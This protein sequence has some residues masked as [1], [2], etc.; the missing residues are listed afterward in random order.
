MQTSYSPSLAGR[1]TGLGQVG[2]PC[3][4]KHGGAVS[5]G[6]N[7]NRSFCS[8]LGK[9]GRPEQCPAGSLAVLCSLLQA[10]WWAAGGRKHD[11][12]RAVG[13]PVGQTPGGWHGGASLTPLCHPLLWPSAHTAA[14]P[15][16]VEHLT[17]V[18]GS[19][20]SCPDAEEYR[21]DACHKLVWFTDS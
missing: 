19:D 13:L 1:S 15:V 9:Q 18:F 8:A 4:S 5:V 17:V 10:G 6:V 16:A 20:G 11:G 21:G 3:A 12:A 7:C 2:A 14:S